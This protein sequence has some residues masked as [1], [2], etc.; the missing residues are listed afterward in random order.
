[1]EPAARRR[2]TLLVCAASVLP[3]ASCYTSIGK[4]TYPSGHYRTTE[5]PHPAPA[6]V[7][8]EPFLDLRG[9]DNTSYMPWSYVPLFPLGWNHFDRPEATVPSSDTTQFRADPDIDLPRAL[10]A[11]L[12][13]SRLVDRAEFA[14]DFNGGRGETHVLRGRLRSFFL[15]ESRITYGLSIYA[16]VMW[17]LALPMGSSTNGFCVDLELAE[18]QSGRVVW[19]ARI[20]E[21][22]EHVEG[23][24]YGP[25]W[26]RFSPMWER[27]LRE[28]LGSLATTL[29]GEAAPLP[30]ELLRDLEET[31]P[32]G[33]VEH[34]G[35]DAAPK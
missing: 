32:A 9:I 26:Y 6:F 27:R 1:M 22:N 33:V 24:Y 14:G 2:G 5:S 11:E 18:R 23:F 13:R 4:W 20:A 21:T 19:Q 29:G 16:P 12:R 3:L 15:D 7:L 8:V 34:P 28:K 30:P 31:P 35:V 17:A 25:E 10:V